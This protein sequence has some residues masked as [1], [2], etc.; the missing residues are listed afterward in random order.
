MG[1]DPVAVDAT[2]ATLMGFDPR[3]IAHIAEA[4]R[5]LG[6]ADMAR[7]EQHG[8]DVTSSVNAFAPAPGFDG[9]PVARR[10]VGSA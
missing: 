8:E 9:L 7:I 2:T 6:Q 4:G 1:D 3:G 5:Y 10:C